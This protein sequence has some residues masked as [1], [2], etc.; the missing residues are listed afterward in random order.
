MTHASS[1]EFDQPVWVASKCALVG[2][3]LR[4]GHSVNL[5]PL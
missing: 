2:L 1:R 3:G 5:D 4:T